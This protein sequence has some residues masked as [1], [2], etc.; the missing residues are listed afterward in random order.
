MRRCWSGCYRLSR[1]K[2][3]AI[4]P[5]RAAGP[6]RPP[7]PAPA[8]R[9]CAYRHLGRARCARAPGGARH[10]RPPHPLPQGRVPPR[11]GRCRAH[12]R[13]RRP[14]WEG[15][16]VSSRRRGHRSLQRQPVQKAAQDVRGQP[17]DI[18]VALRDAVRG[19]GDHGYGARV[20]CLPLFSG[21]HRTSCRPRHLRFEARPL[22]FRGAAGAA[23]CCPPRSSRRARSR[24]GRAAPAAPRPSG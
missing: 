3:P 10:L 12:E 14:H 9:A 22:S 4:V 13:G 23:G 5:S 6:S 20:R 2:S 21:R 17:R 24:P 15:A 18:R 1:A 7:S 11:H 19:C 8:S 16:G